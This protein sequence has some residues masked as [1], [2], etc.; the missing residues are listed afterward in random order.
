MIVSRATDL[1]RRS[2]IDAKQLELP[3]RLRDSR[4]F[5]EVGAGEGRWGQVRAGGE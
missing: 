1:W 3:E 4:S 2:Q 5:G